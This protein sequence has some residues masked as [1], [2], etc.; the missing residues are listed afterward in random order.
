M[1]IRTVTFEWDDQKG[2]CYTCGNP[3]A[4]RSDD[5]GDYQ[6]APEGLRCA[7]C[8]AYDASHGASIVYLF[9]DLAA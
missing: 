7:V 3:A 4:Y 1:A 8:A 2:D 6:D 9:D 5:A